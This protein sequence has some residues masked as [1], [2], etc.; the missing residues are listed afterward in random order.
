MHEPY[1]YVCYH[2]VIWFAIILLVAIT[3]IYSS[4]LRFTSLARCLFFIA[5]VFYQQL[6]VRWAT[7]GG[8]GKVEVRAGVPY[9][10]DLMLDDLRWS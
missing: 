8:S 3:S 5:S 4:Q 6:Q 9:L 1:Y 7:K 10:R 2:I